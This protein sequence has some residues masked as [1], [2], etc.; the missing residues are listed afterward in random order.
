MELGCSGTQGQIEVGPSSSC[1]VKER[2]LSP[3][4]AGLHAGWNITSTLGMHVTGVRST[5]LCL[6]RGMLMQLAAATA[7]KGTN[8]PTKGGRCWGGKVSF[9]GLWSGK[10]LLG[11]RWE[12]VGQEGMVL[13]KKKLVGKG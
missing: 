11:E 1:P 5:H 9:S 2:G 10:G 8:L 6:I 4:W 7:A 13:G 3:C 12:P